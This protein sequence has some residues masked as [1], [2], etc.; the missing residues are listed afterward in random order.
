MWLTGTAESHLLVTG[1]LLVRRLRWGSR[2]E[3]GRAPQ[4]ERLTR[5]RTHTHTHTQMYVVSL[6]H[7]RTHTHRVAERARAV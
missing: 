1:G 4:A 2:K 6:T 5:T 7:T 3:A